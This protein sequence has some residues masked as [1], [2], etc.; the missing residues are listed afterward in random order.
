MESRQPWQIVSCAFADLAGWQTD[1][2]LSALAAFKSSAARHLHTPYKQRRIPFDAAAFNAACRAS[3]AIDLEAARE[4]QTEAKA[5]FEFWFEPFLIVPNQV[6]E[7]TTGK[8]TGYYEPVIE[9]RLTKGL[10]FETPFL[11]RPHDLVEL[12]DAEAQQHHGMRFGRRRQNAFEPYFDRPAIDGGAL[13]NRNLEIAWVR[14]PVDAFFAHVQGCARLKL[15]DKT[16]RIT[17]DGKSGHEFTGIGRVLIERGEIAPQNI[18]MQAIRAW[19]KANSARRDEI[20]HCNPSYIFFREEA[21]A[22]DALGPV[23]AA[24]VPISPGRSIAIDRTIHSFGLPFFIHAPHFKTMQP[25]GSQAGSDQG[26]ARLMMA[27]DTGS[28]I[29]GAARADVFIGSGDAAGAIAG[30]I[31]HPAQFYI[32]LPRRITL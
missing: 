28:A 13:N 21:V 5:F 9:A 19:L 22:D 30:V 2:H 27:H 18:S 31:N 20:L 3:L 23:A 15:P 4:T 11:R 25:A 24:K 1:D 17:Y 29:L 12:S 26:F 8:I 32:L 10:G 14:D 6:S 16:I 7:N